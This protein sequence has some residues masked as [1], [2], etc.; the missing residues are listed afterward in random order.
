MRPKI[1]SR[2]R[3]SSNTLSSHGVSQIEECYWDNPRVIGSD[4]AD[5]GV[6][7]NFERQRA[8]LPQT[9]GAYRQPIVGPRSGICDDLTMSSIMDM[10]CG[11]SLA[12]LHS[13]S[14]EISTVALITKI[15]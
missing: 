5:L 6:H 9:T 14:P 10:T 11:V 12:N 1:D 3:G 8:T 13:F 7:I 4:I 2:L 15:A